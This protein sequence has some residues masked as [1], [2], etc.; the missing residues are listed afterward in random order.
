MSSTSSYTSPI[1]AGAR[2]VTQR[3]LMKSL[4]WSITDVTVLGR[5]RLKGVS[6][7]VIVVANHSSHLDTPLILGALPRKL[8]RWIAIGAA[9]AYF[10]DVKWRRGVTSLFFNLFPIN[11]PGEKG[12]SERRGMASTL[13]DEGVPLLIY[14][15]ATRSR[16]GEMA[17]FTAGPAALSRSRGV[18]CLPIGLVGTFDAMPYGANWPKRGR[19]SVYVN[20]GAPLTAEPD[21]TV[22]EY[23]ARMAKEVRGL[24]DEAEEYRAARGR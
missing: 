13:L 6:S 19:P 15:E 7:P 2:V 4:V 9:G 21:E 3:L 22:P 11:R 23:A 24:I 10:F 17:P 5:E 8:S 1:R 14:P 18:P 16:T 12:K 20:L